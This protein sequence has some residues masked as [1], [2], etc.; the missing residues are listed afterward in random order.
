MN[1]SL[2]LI[3]V[4]LAAIG[5]SCS[6][7]EPMTLENYA[8]ATT[9]TTESYVLESQQISLR[10]QTAVEDQVRELVSSSDQPDLEGAMTIVRSETAN[11]LALLDDAMG[12]YHTDLEELT[13]PT[14]VA[15]QHEAYLKI[16]ASVRSTLPTSRDALADT[17]TFE[18]I[19]SSLVGSGFA[20]GQTA[21]TAACE[22]LE[23]AIRGEG[24]GADLKC[25]RDQLGS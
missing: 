15:E 25:V 7:A 22:L 1:R 2:V 23:S 8:T 18:E 20:D 17:T 16:I 21:W 9:Q 3:L 11:F 6:E 4:V 12:R 10:Y 19:L 14:P 13:P 24:R 5:A